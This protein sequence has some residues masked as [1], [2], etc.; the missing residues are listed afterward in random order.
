MADD[1]RNWMA[2][3]ELLVE[4]NFLPTRSKG[5]PFRFQVGFQVGL[6]WGGLGLC[7]HTTVCSNIFTYQVQ[8]VPI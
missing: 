5:C 3:P 2:F 8:G 7:K 1:S 4:H 6:F